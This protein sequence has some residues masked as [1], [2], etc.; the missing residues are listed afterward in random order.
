MRERT[1][2][3]AGRTAPPTPGDPARRLPGSTTVTVLAGVVLLAYVVLV[4]LLWPEASSQASLSRARLAPS[5]A[6]WFGTDYAGHDLFVRVAQGLRVSLTIAVLC[7]L[8][9]TVAGL[10]VGLTAAALGGRTDAVLMRIS[11]AVN[12]LPHLLLGIVLVALFRGSLTAIVVSIA[13]THWPQV[14]RIVRSEALTTRAAEF[15]DAA[16]LAGASRWQVLA[17]HLLPATLA[18]AS[19]AVVL[20]VP[21]AIWHESTLSFLGLGL[22]PDRPS[23]GTLLQQSRGEILLGGWWSLAFPALALVVATLVVSGLASAARHRWAP[24]ADEAQVR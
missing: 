3:D 8:I 22:S 16:Y 1:W 7:A 14:A 15:V 6:H 23:L 10:A 18:Q 12:A 24:L 11:D 13:V 5:A 4:P 19:V 20:L 9:A 2:Q 21:H 17:R